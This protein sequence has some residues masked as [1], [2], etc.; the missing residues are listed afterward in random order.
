MK[1]FIYLDHAPYQTFDRQEDI[2]YHFNILI[3]LLQA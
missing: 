3:F 2:S 1:I